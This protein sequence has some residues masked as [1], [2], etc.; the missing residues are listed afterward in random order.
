M[1]GAVPSARQRFPRVRS[2]RFRRPAKLLKSGL[3]WEQIPAFFPL[4]K[5]PKR[6]SMWYNKH[7]VE[8]PLSGYNFNNL[9]KSPADRKAPCREL[10]PR[11][12]NGAEWPRTQP[13][14]LNP[15]PNQN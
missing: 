3:L 7:W 8:S 4:L 11:V 9:I 2:R 1:R 15:L 13:P 14:L 6:A 5:G 12:L 10:D